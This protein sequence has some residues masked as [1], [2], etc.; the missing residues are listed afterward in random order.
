MKPR[1][2]PVG[3]LTVEA[4]VAGEA[5]PYHRLFS[6]EAVCPPVPG[7]LEASDTWQLSMKV[8]EL[9]TQRDRLD[10]ELR[11]AEELLKL[12]EDHGCEDISEAREALARKA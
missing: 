6:E 10:A 2:E 1:R 4:L 3:D 9:R 8:Q 5:K 11:E 12:D 7:L